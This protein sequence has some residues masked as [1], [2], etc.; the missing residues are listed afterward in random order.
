MI[1][2]KLNNMKKSTAVIVAVLLIAAC[3]ADVYQAYLT[4]I[5]A[6]QSE[7]VKSRMASVDPE[8]YRDPEKK[9]VTEVLEKTEA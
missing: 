6:M 1:S 2:K 7:G 9:E 4:E 5:R 3:I 8:L